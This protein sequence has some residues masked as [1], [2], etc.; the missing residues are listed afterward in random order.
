MGGVENL[1]TLFQGFDV[2]LE[3]GV[4][5]SI[6]VF[7]PTPGAEWVEANIDPRVP[8]FREDAAAYLVEAY[9]GLAERIF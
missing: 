1:D 3:Q 9:M 4:V 2:L 5:P 6:T 7:Y 8:A